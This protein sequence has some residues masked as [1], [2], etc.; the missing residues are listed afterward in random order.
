MNAMLEKED[1]FKK[2]YGM[3]EKKSAPLQGKGLESDL[4]RSASNYSPDKIDWAEASGYY[5]KRKNSV[6]LQG[7]GLGSELYE[8]L[9]TSIS[10]SGKKLDIPENLTE[11]I[12]SGFGIDAT[13]LSLRESSEVA[14][15]GAQATAQGNVIRFAPGQ[16][17]PDTTEGQRILGHELNHVREQAQGKVKPNIEGTDIHFDPMNEAASDRAGEAFASGILNDAS[18]VSIGQASVGGEAVQGIFRSIFNGIENAS[19]FV[20][21][22]AGQGLGSLIG[23]QQ[24]A[25]KEIRSEVPVAEVPITETPIDDPNAS[26]VT[27]AGRNISNV[28]NIDDVNYMGLREM[29]YALEGVDGDTNAALPSEQQR[30]VWDEENRQAIVRVTNRE[31]GELSENQYFNIDERSE[32]NGFLVR[33]GRIVINS[34]RLSD[35]AGV[36]GLED[37]LDINSDEYGNQ[38]VNLRDGADNESNVTVAGR[39][40]SNVHNIDDVNYMGLREMIYALEGVDGDANADLPLEQQRVVW[41]EENRR[42]TI[43][44]TN[45]ET[46]ELVSKYF[47]IDEQGEENGFLVRDDRIVI[48]NDRLSDL[49]GLAGLEDFLDIHSDEYGNQVVNLSDREDNDSGASSQL[50]GIPGVQ[51]L[52]NLWESFGN[53]GGR[54]GGNS[55]GEL[56]GSE[57]LNNGVSSGLEGAANVLQRPPA[58]LPAPPSQIINPA[59][60][61]PFNSPPA[62]PGLINPATNLPFNSPPVSSGLINPATNLPFNSPPVSSGLINPATNL[63]FNS[64]PV[65][66]GLINPATNLPFNSPPVPSG[67]INPATN[68]PFNSPPVSPGTI[69]DQRGNPINNV[70]NVTQGNLGRYL[71]TGGNVLGKISTAMDMAEIANSVTQDIR[72]GYR[73]SAE[74]VETTLGIGGAMAAGWAGAKGGAKLGALIGSIIP[75]KGTAVGAVVGGAL[76]FVGGMAGAALG[77]LAGRSFGGGLADGVNERT[78][79]FRR[80]GSRN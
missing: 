25:K 76:G 72:G 66:S 78:G 20:G 14:K 6:P 38:I 12:Q 37:F 5:K 57:W 71:Q 69:L 17:N 49:A 67:L 75:V 9:Q 70:P 51:N 80:R 61:L 26:N 65:S 2:L 1:M 3:K 4:L 45:R 79:L 63:P 53:F 64:P 56:I 21:N 68:L 74:T 36:A 27:V 16:Y 29:I 50:P 55:P 22:L 59:T 23:G 32:E 13:K 47:N 34:D 44:V 73:V 30:V 46:G 10:D 33:D 7:K 41:D 19:R 39:N 24:G 18:P 60:N 35:L 62:S 8:S 42:A 77:R 43:R 48:N 28:H 52:V 31:T 58:N 54:L 15:M 40:I 11:S